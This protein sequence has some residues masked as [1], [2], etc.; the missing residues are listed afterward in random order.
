MYIVYHHLRWYACK[1]LDDFADFPSI[2]DERLWLSRKGDDGLSLP[3]PASR[4]NDRLLLEEVQDLS[5]RGR[6]ISRP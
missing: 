2:I 1:I 5:S 4:E 3:V 6:V